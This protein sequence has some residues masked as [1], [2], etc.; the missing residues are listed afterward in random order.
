MARPHPALLDLAAGRPMPAPT[1][2][3]TLVVSAREHRMGGLLWS[4]ASFGGIELGPGRSRTLLAD[5]L[6][7]RNRVRRMW[8]AIDSIAGTLGTLGIEIATFKGV[9]AQA[10]WYDRE[11]ERPCVD[12]DVLVPPG[13]ERRASEILHVFAPDHVLV[14]DASRFASSG[15]LQSLQFRVDDVPIDLHFDMLKMGI[16]S[17]LRETIWSRTIPFETPSGRAVRVPDSETALLQFLMHLN[18]DR[19][20]YLLGFVDVL[21]ILEREEVDM[22]TLRDLARI[23]GMDVPVLSSLSVV[24]ETLGLPTRRPIVSGLRARAWR[25]MWRPSV[26]LR[27]DLGAVRYRFRQASLPLFTGR[28]GATLR[29][30]AR[31]PFPPRPLVAYYHR[32]DKGGYLRHITAG[33]LRG[34]IERN[35][36]ASRLR[37]PAESDRDRARVPTRERD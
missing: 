26:R 9:S 1:D 2:P 33:R 22:A 30:W 4:V 17:R 15:V 18:K 16:P 12:V 6:L 36:A 24:Q 21:R 13:T 29:W 37:T 14:E 5:D 23:D 11:G 7:F 8:G 3:Q 19:F 27:G 20:R 31:K 32:S 28:V 25:S 35:R 10:R 34:A